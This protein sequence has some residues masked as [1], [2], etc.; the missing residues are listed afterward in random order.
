MTEKYTNLI[1]D[2]L[3]IQSEVMHEYNQTVGCLLKTIK[4]S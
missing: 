3:I 2:K 1:K 4:I